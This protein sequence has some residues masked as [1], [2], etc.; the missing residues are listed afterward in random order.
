MCCGRGW[1]GLL[2]QHCRHDRRQN[3]HTHEKQD[4]Q[5]AAMIPQPMPSSTDSR[6][7]AIIRLH[8]AFT[9]P[10]RISVAL[11]VGS[12]VARILVAMVVR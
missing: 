4:Q 1:I 3:Q 5:H 8:R 12:G 11:L 6:W 7:D 10:E 2:A 9:W